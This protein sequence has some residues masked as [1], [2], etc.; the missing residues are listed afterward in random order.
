MV[1]EKVKEAA[2][3]KIDKAVRKAVKKGVDQELV[4]QTVDNAIIK[5]KD[6][7]PARPKASAGRKRG[8][9]KTKPRK[10]T[11]RDADAE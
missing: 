8:N 11:I 7:K 6:K 2:V 5:A 9:V 3:K 10:A 1:K 4:T